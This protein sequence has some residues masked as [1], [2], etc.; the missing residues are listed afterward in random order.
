M[1]CALGVGAL[2]IGPEI[3]PGVPWTLGTDDPARPLWLA[4]KSGNFGGR[5]FFMDAIA[6]LEGL[7]A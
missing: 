7:P 5:D 2:S 4:L 1:I 6:A 3:A